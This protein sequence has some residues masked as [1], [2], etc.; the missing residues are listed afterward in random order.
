MKTVFNRGW[1]P[2]LI[3]IIA[4]LGLVMEW[5]LEYVA[6]VLIVILCAGTLG[7][8]TPEDTVCGGMIASILDGELSANASRAAKL[9]RK[10]KDNIHQCLCD[11]FHGKDLIRLGF[12]DDLKYAAQV[13]IT[14]VLPVLNSDG[15]II[16]GDIRK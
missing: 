7:K 11:S 8:E 1:Y 12:S 15:R 9:Y 10:Y 16:R 4:V 13:G 3:T 2:A 6:P 5:P 14:S